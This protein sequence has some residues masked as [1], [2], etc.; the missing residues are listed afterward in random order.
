MPRP[1]T[2]LEK[3][4]GF[5]M[6]SRKFTFD[7]NAFKPRGDL[8]ANAIRESILRGTF[9]PGDKLDQQEI[10]DQFTVSRIPVREALRTLD[11]EGLIT[12]IPNRGAIVTKRTKNELEELYY[13]RRLLEGA[14]VERAVPVMTEDTLD[15]LAS[16]I[17]QAYET[18]EHETLLTLN[19]DFHIAMYSA[20]PQP[21]LVNYIQ[22]LRNV[23]APYNPIYLDHP[24]AKEAAWA[25][26]EEIYEACRY[27]EAEEARLATERHLDRVIA[28]IVSAIEKG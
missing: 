23:V 2:I 3:D 25:E 22:Q 28:S 18:D 9:R 26:H 27:G 21:N 15:Q 20:Y 24:G 8:I 5:F 17:E 10:A 19:N 14:A 1:S 16:F 12:M 4:A 11:A 13:I 6:S 7:P